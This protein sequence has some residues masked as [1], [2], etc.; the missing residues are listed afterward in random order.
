MA[1]SSRFDAWAVAESYEAYMGRWSRPIGAHY[2]RWL[3]MP[4]GLDWLDL[5]C[6]TGALT[7][8]IVRQCH[9]AT[10]IAIDPS[11]TFIVKARTAISDP[12]VKFRV[13]GASSLSSIAAASCDVAV[14]GLVLNFIPER[15]Q[16]LG[17]MKRIVRPGGTV[18]FY[19]WDYPGGGLEFARAFWSA[20]VTLDSCARD[21]VELGRF[22]FCTPEGLAELAERAEL[23]KVQLIAIE[24]PSVF[25]DFEDYWHPFTLGAGP[26][27][28]YCASLSAEARERL[29]K[30]LSD[31]LPRQQDGSIV[32][33][34][35]A[36]AVRCQVE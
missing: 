33:Q 4:E 1:E 10:V 29:R 25:R 30:K 9:P 27:P 28:G 35:R 8:A 36:W 11:E 24:S 23:G 7:A 26:A 15:V 19:V 3:D 12:R 13:G 20:A 34:T 6:G 31:C 21:V 18:G 14:A 16:A 2:L 22:S 32:L 17:E 5:G